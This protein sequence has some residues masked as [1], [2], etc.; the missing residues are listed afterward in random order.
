MFYI[1]R[2]A[3]DVFVDKMKKTEDSLDWVMIGDLKL[4]EQPYPKWITWW[5]LPAPGEGFGDV[6]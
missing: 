1:G 3:Q 6:Y 4:V 5:T 2:V